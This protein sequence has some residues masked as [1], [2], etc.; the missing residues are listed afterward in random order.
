QGGDRDAGVG[1][2]VEVGGAGGREVAPAGAAAAA[3]GSHAG[4]PHL[5]PGEERLAEGP[6]LD[7]QH[8]AAG[9][10]LAVHRSLEDAAGEAA[11]VDQGQA[12][13]ADPA[14]AVAQSGD[15]GRA[16]R[17][18]EQGEKAGEEPG[19]DRRGEEDLARA[20]FQYRG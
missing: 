15:P 18:D 13:V 12:A 10:P 1:L 11:V 20:T 2:D 19:G 6:L 5:P 9:H 3:G 16:P 17:T 14:A 4:L 8:L 7:E